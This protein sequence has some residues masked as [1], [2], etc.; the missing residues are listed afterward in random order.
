[1]TFLKSHIS[2]SALLSH[3][4]GL[5]PKYQLDGTIFFK[6]YLFD[7]PIFAELNPY[8]SQP[9]IAH[10]VSDL[11]IY[12]ADLISL[13]LTDDFAAFDS[14]ISASDSPSNAVLSQLFF[15]GISLLRDQTVIDTY[16]QYFASV[17][18]P[19]STKLYA[20][21]GTLLQ[22]SH[23][24]D[25]HHE[26]HRAYSLGIKYFKFR[27]PVGTQLSHEQRLQSP[28]S[29]NFQELENIYTLLSD[30]FSGVMVDFGCRLSQSQLVEHFSLLRSFEFIEEPI[31]RSDYL[32]YDN[33]HLSNVSGGEFCS[34]FSNLMQLCARQQ[35]FTLIQPDL[36]L[37]PAYDLKLFLSMFPTISLSI[38]NWTTPISALH[39]FSIAYAVN[40][41]FLEWPVIDNVFYDFFS[42]ESDL[43]SYFSPLNKFFSTYN[44][45]LFSTPGLITKPFL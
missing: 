23:I 29:V 6:L 39:N 44:E 14:F 10:I 42:D 8:L 7:T 27:P 11:Y 4:S 41:Q 24:S 13:I 43:F 21:G 5:L 18:Y 3:R 20:S 45:F 28:P 9:Q 32:S 1:M 25:L 15:S 2:E 33:L 31:P 38:H 34:S 17:H 35:G 19:L 30:L 36:N 40:A 22:F 37:L 16:Q 26:F 12:Q